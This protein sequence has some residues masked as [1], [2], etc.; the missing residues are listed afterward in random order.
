[1]VDTIISSVQFC[2]AVLESPIPLLVFIM[3]S[4][5]NEPEPS[6][7]RRVSSR[8]RDQGVE[9]RPID[10]QCSALRDRTEQVQSLSAR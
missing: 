5:N 8:L 6:F 3:A 9:L 7:I 10:P 2:T 1:M 4:N